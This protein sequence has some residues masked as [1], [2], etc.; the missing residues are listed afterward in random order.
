MQV[1]LDGFIESDVL[2]NKYI[3]WNMSALG[4]LQFCYI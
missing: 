2:S 4:I 1:A 3:D